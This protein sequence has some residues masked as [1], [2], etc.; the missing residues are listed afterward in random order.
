MYWTI[1]GVQRGEVSGAAPTGRHFTGESISTIRFR[2][3]RIV[4][5]RVLPD[6]LGI[7]Q[8]LVS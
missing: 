1:E 2:D 3:G 5:D 4:D 7:V 8:Q 6:R